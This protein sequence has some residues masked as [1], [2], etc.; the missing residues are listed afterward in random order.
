MPMSEILTVLT[1]KSARHII[2]DGGTQ[3]WVI[4]QRRARRCPYVVCV[5]HQQG[6]YKAEGDEPHKHA[7]L[8]GKVKDVVPSSEV[9]DR[10]RVEMSEYAI[11]DGPHISLNSASPTQYFPTLSSIGIDEASLHWKP[12]HTPPD[13]DGGIPR[14]GASPNGGGFPTGNSLQDVSDSGV[15]PTMSIIMQ[16]KKLIS[17]GLHVPLSSV[18]IIVRA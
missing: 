2:G 3:S 9:S 8:V 11:L 14:G 16:A 6:P 17:D 18:E 1:F 10:F 7:F 5:R 12:I 15:I 4:S 13:G